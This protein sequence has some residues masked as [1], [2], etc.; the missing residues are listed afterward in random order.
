[1]SRPIALRAA[2]AAIALLAGGAA[3]LTACSEAAP[4]AA[5]PE[6]TATAPREA[7]APVATP[8]ATATAP[9]EAAAPVANP[10]PTPAQQAA[11][12]TASPSPSPAPAPPD[13]TPTPTASPP[14]G[15][16]T[17]VVTTREE[18][19]EGETKGSGELTP[20]D[21]KPP[22]TDPQPAAAAARAADAATPEQ[23]ERPYTWYDG[24]RTRKVWLESDGAEPVFRTE[25]GAVMTLPG[26]VVLVLDASWDEAAVEG[27]FAEHGIARSSVTEQSFG[28]NAYLVDTEPGLPS[29]ELA[30][31][32]AVQDGVRISS[33]NWRRE[34]ET[35]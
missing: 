7:A 28:A 4:H 1:M 13:P 3:I 20:P 12:P 15:S 14:T 30:N 22:R 6:A 10:S 18:E 24:D 31:A 34:V 32:L 23:E 11:A 21:P 26:G 25:S 9:R 2:F 16:R 35:R 19:A 8:E 27:F 5:T 33:P 29:L 17:V